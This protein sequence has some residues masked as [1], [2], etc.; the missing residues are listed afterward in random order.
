MRIRSLLTGLTVGAVAAV[1]AI[2]PTQA[3]TTSDSTTAVVSILHAVP[4]T[5]VDVYVNHHRLL[6][7]FQPGTFAGPLNV[8]AGSYTITITA[9]S[10]TNDRHPVIG[11]L[12]VRFAAHQNYT[13]AAHLTAS[14]APTATLYTNPLAPTADESGRLIVRHD[15]AAPAVDVLANGSA[16]IKGLTNPGQ[17]ILRVKEGTYSA[18]VALAGTTKPVIGPAKVRLDE[19]MDTI[20]YAWGSAKAGNLMLAVQ[21]VYTH[22]G[23]D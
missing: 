15:A 16:I 12:T 13:V 11:P 1:G 20:V 9:A 8:K 21:T 17:R 5:P 18:A 19:G 4:K 10:A 23:E 3:A 7:D 6:N 22:G 14:G 2:V